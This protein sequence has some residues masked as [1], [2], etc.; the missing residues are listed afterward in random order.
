MVERRVKAA[1]FPAVKS[2]DTFDFLAIP[3]VNKQLVTRLARCEYVERRENITAMGNSGTGKIHMALG[4]GL[5]ACQ[6]GLS[7]GFTTADALCTS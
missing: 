7:V 3:P 5:A 1:R 2:L 6:R 4:L